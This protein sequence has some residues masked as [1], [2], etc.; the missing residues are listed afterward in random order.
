MEPAKLAMLANKE[1]TSPSNAKAGL[2][3]S[4]LLAARALPDRLS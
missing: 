2:I 3:T 1:N 4:V